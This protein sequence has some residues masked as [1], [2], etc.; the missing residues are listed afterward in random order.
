MLVVL[1][2]CGSLIALSGCES[3]NKFM[4]FQNDNIVENLTEDL[5]EYETGRQIDL[6]PSDKDEGLHLY[7]RKR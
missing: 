1:I 2:A 4:G 3:V 6:T 7:E 5:I